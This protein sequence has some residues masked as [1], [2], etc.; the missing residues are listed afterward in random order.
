M[1]TINL[2]FKLGVNLNQPDLENEL[3]E[4]GDIDDRTAMNKNSYGRWFRQSVFPLV[5]K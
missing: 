3:A 5:S 1:I 4:L 2:C